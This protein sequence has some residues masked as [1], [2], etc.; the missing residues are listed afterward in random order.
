MALLAAPSPNYALLGLGIVLAILFFILSFVYF[1]HAANALPAFLP[2][3]ELGNTKVHIKHGVAAAVLGLAGI[4]L[5][6]FASK[7]KA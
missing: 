3:Y 4:T 1:S 6:W 2:G 5:A 7:P